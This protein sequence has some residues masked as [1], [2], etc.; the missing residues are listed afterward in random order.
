[1]ASKKRKLDKLKMHLQML[2]DISKAKPLDT[3]VQTLCDILNNSS[4]LKQI[5]LEVH[6]LLKIYLTIPVP[7]ASSE[8]TFS[9]LKR[10]MTYLCNSMTQEHFNHCLI[11]HVQNLVESAKEFVSRCERRK[12]EN[13]FWKLLK[14]SLLQ[15][16]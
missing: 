1:M 7:T 6:K 16:F 11:L 4:G 2:P 12:K 14:I 5:I 10:I 13:L 9:A 15:G 3:R 8:C